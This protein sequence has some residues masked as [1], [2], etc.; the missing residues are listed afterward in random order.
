MTEQS[1]RA[2]KIISDPFQEWSRTAPQ[3][4]ADFAEWLDAR[5][6]ELEAQYEAW[7]TLGYGH[8]RKGFAG[9]QR[10]ASLGAETETA[11]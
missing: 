6:L 9:R 10:G 5:L 8:W 2:P 3:T 7:G 4:Y 11:E 1:K